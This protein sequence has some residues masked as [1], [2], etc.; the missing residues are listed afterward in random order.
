MT[1]KPALGK[2]LGALIPLEQ[3]SREEQG[4]IFCRIE[5][6]LPNPNQPRNIFDP[7]GLKALAGTIK[8]RG[9]LQPL[10]VRRK[11]EGYE[12]IAGERRLRAAKIA[13]LEKV[14]IIIYE[15]EARDSLEI[16]LLENLQ[17]E[18]LNPI[19]EARAYKTLL[20][21][22]GLTQEELAKRVGKDR[23]SLT[24]TLR[25]LNLPKEIQ[26]EIESGVLTPGHGRALLSVEHSDLQVRAKNIIKNKKL[27]VR[28][29]EIYVKKLQSEIKEKIKGNKIFDDPDINHLQ[30]ELCKMYGT[31]IKIVKRGKGG[32]IQIYFY[33]LDDL[34]RLYSLLTR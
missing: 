6:I 20:E 10:I 26:Q 3:G 25:L 5:D 29:T 11:G 12:L 7:E 32:E 21:H 2:G 19:E 22:T 27:S 14:P 1:K 24:N 13:G 31:R 30:D 15:A 17:R 23:S 4:I 28:E 8:D 18:N 34:D 16:S 9:I 33:T